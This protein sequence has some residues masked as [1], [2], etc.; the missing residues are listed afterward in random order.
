MVSWAS[1]CAKSYML[2]SKTQLKMASR[3]PVLLFALMV[4]LVIVSQGVL[5]ARE[6]VE[7]TKGN[8]YLCLYIWKRPKSRYFGGHRNFINI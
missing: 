4:C 8:I 1:W 3:S 2:I 5:A 7:T 6:L